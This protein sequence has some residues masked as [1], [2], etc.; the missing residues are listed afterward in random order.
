MIIGSVHIRPAA[1]EQREQI[2]PTRF[3]SQVY[4]VHTIEAELLFELRIRVQQFLHVRRA[5]MV[6]DGID[7]RP[8]WMWER[9]PRFLADNEV[10]MRRHNEQKPHRRHAQHQ[11]H[12]P[13]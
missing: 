2:G 3:R 7:Q 10:N 9:D 6:A 11:R 5:L 4:S 1:Q 12:H 13:R 8:V